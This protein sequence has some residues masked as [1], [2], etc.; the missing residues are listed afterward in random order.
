MADG[1]GEAPIFREHQYFAITAC[2]SD[3]ST[4]CASQRA[5]GAPLKPGTYEFH[6]GGS[7]SAVVDAK[8]GNPILP[9]SSFDTTDTIIVGHPT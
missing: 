8:T 5:D 7:M 9:A 3:S 6:F 2:G 1:V 4:R